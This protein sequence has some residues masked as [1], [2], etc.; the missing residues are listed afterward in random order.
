MNA[1]K[2]RCL[3]DDAAI[4]Y[5]CISCQKEVKPCQQAFM[6]DGC[7]RWQHRTCSTGVTQQEYR[8]AVQKKTS[9]DWKCSDCLGEPST[10]TPPA[11]LNITYTIVPAT[12]TSPDFDPS[13]VQQPSPLSSTFRS[14]PTS[15]ASTNASIIQPPS[16]LASTSATSPLPVTAPT[17]PDINQL[18]DRSVTS[19][20]TLHNIFVYSVTASKDLV[21]R[22]NVQGCSATLR[23]LWSIHAF[24]KQN[25][26]TKQVPLLFVLMS[27][28]CKEDYNK[29]LAYLKEK[30]PHPMT[31]TEVVM[32][33]EHAVW[34]SFRTTLPDVTLRG[35][36]FHWS[37]CVWKRIQDEGLAPAYRQNNKYFV[38]FRL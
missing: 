12:P 33:F 25:D 38:F 1:T 23:Q 11:T 5:L 16:P 15:P 9:I 7:S 35:C 18:P 37:Q 4:E 30:L 29:I 14:P 6:C 28:R 19:C 17:S 10:S 21:C 20:D 26:C 2:R 8:L 31:V 34:S 22:R 32:D 36:S 24:L 27:R 3:N 13:V